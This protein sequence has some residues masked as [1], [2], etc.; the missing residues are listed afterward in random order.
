[1]VHP[2]LVGSRREEDTAPD[3][4]TM[5]WIPLAVVQGE[6]AH[7]AYNYS[8]MWIEIKPQQTSARA[9]GIPFLW[10]GGHATDPGNLERTVRSE[11]P[12]IG[13]T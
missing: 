1:M 5:W 13:Q 8:G 7:L 12:E 2:M 3:L 9:V 6:I 11:G 4:K 10:R